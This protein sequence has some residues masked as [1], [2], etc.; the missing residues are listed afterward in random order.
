M[1]FLQENIVVNFCKVNYE[2]SNEDYQNFLYSSQLPH[3][4]L[5]EVVQNEPYQ[6]NQLSTSDWIQKNSYFQ[7]YLQ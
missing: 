7:I 2:K 1:L 5:T 6:W 3:S 4:I